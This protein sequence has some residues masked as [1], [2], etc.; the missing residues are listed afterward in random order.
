ME[1][2]FDT[3]MWEQ[4]M[5]WQAYLCDLETNIEAL[6]AFRTWLHLSPMER[7]IFEDKYPEFTFLENDELIIEMQTELLSA[8]N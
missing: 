7:T 6:K 4:P 3:L 5:R 1:K 8:L 2:L